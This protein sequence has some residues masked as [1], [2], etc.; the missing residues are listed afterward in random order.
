MGVI[1]LCIA[2][3]AWNGSKEEVHLA[4]CGEAQGFAS[5]LAMPQVTSTDVGD[6]EF[7][8]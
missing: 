1:C 6:F 5:P 3:S 2:P 4:C 8:F 7:F